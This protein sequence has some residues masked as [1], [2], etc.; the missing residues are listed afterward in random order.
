[1]RFACCFGFA[2]ATLLAQSYEKRALQTSSNIAARHLPFG[3][4]LDPVF[5]S[6][7]SD[8]IVGYS[9]CGD[10]AIWTGH[11][12]AAE[13]FR[14]SVARSDEAL[15]A[16]RRALDGLRL[17]IDVTGTNNLLA[18]CA[19]PEESPYLAGISSEESHHSQFSG[20]FAGDKYVWVG[21]TSRD[22]YLG[23]F[24]GFTTAYENVAD[25]EVRKQIAGLATRLTDRLL[26]N[27]WAV[28]MPDGKLSTVFWH[29]PDQQLAI[30]QVAR[31]VNPDR[32]AS[33]YQEHRRKLFSV[34]LPIWLELRDQHSSYFKF[35]LAAITF[36]MLLRLEKQD[37]PRREEYW[38]AYNMFR[39]ATARHGNA[40]FTVIERALAGAGADR[41]AE[42]R[43]LMSE[44]LQRPARD[45]WVDL[46]SKYKSCGGDRACDVIPVPERVRTDFLWQRSPYL[47]YGGGRGTIEAPGIDWLLPYWMA[48]R[49][50]LNLDR[51]N[52]GENRPERTSIRTEPFSGDYFRA[53]NCC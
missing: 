4:I 27:G 26:A 5:K 14:Y 49:Y 42:I 46:R 12:L 48:R 40:F 24:F 1:M 53:L 21:N 17:L 29:R 52:P 30:L 22:Q 33:A 37:S 41:D 36:Y 16:V 15:A 3:T 20:S 32:F 11:Y 25:A 7:E 51:S 2:I 39:D 45:G 6:P 35:N 43:R 31:Q 44:W 47:L 9:R 18:R 28:T 19:V 34:R 23:A 8:E 50:G 13:S 38:G 10:S